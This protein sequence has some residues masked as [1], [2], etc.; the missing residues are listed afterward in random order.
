MLEPGTAALVFSRAGMTRRMKS[1]A[2]AILCAGLIAAPLGVARAD[3][4]RA[5]LTSFGAAGGHF[6]GPRDGFGPAFSYSTGDFSNA[7]YLYPGAPAPRT[8]FAASLALSPSF[9][10]DSG[11]DLDIA[12]RLRNFDALKSPLIMASW[13]MMKIST[14]K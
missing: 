12:Q 1:W 3:S 5:G 11:Y 6:V 13:R 8:S 7:F 14:P 4:A 9:A 10:L 2:K